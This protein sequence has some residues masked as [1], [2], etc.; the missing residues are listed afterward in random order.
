[1]KENVIDILM[2]LLQNASLEEETVEHD[3]ESLKALLQDAGYANGEIHEAF[4]WLDDLDLQISQ[5]RPIK[6]ADHSFRSVSSVAEKQR[7]E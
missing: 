6:H 1:M 7:K 4:R 2:Y 5:Q 3:H